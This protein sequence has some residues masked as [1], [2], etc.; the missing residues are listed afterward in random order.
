[1][2][3]STRAE[4]RNPS[5]TTEQKILNLQKC[6]FVICVLNLMLGSWVKLHNNLWMNLFVF[7]VD[8]N[9]N[10]HWNKH[11]LTL[12]GMFDILSVNFRVFLR[13]SLIKSY[14]ADILLICSITKILHVVAIRIL[15]SR[16]WSQISGNFMDAIKYFLGGKSSPLLGCMMARN[17]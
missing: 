1:M 12:I 4:G 3:R 16:V 10:V 2:H 17:I 5:L 13:H 7:I 15:E 6:T 11:N 9:F 14:G 8:L